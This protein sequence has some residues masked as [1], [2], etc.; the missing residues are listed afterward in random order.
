MET[1]T[2]SQIASARA[3]RTTRPSTTMRPA[4]PAARAVCSGTSDSNSIVPGTATIRRKTSELKPPPSPP[5]VTD[6]VGLTAGTGTPAGFGAVAVGLG[7]GLAAVGLGSGWSFASGLAFG[8]AAGLE[9]PAG[10]DVPD[11]LATEPGGELVEGADEV[12]PELELPVAEDQVVVG[13]VVAAGFGAGAG[14]GLGFGVVVVAVGVVTVGAGS[15]AGSSASAVGAKAATSDAPART[16]A[17]RTRIALDAGRA[18]QLTSL[19]SPFVALPLSSLSVRAGRGSEP[20]Q[21]SGKSRYVRPT[22]GRALQGKVIQRAVR[23]HT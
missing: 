17:A 13:L 14:F 9:A 22:G 11:E 3:A 15:G 6:A 2:P 20:V 4:A 18:P 23:C 16:A 7:A 5:P 8:V 12:L 10:L 1:K 19:D 21:K